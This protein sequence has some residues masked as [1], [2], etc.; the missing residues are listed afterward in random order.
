MRETTERKDVYDECLSEISTFVFQH[1]F[2]LDE[3]VGKHWVVS[4]TSFQPATSA[5]LLRK[6]LSWVLHD[7]D[8]LIGV[9]MIYAFMSLRH[10]NRLVLVWCSCL[11]M[12]PYKHRSRI[13]SGIGIWS[14]SRHR[15][16][17]EMI[18]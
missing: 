3:W 14:W 13:N 6:L 15:D 11:G 9:Y 7:T 2:L 8:G 10:I 5:T 4:W 17:T 18:L 12:S 1:R 16:K